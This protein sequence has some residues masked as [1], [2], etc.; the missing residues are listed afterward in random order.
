MLLQSAS[1]YSLLAIFTRGSIFPTLR[2][3]QFRPYSAFNSNFHLTRS[4]KKRKD[5]NSK[6]RFFESLVILCPKRNENSI[7]TRKLP[8]NFAIRRPITEFLQPNRIRLSRQFAAFRNPNYSLFVSPVNNSNYR[9]NHSGGNVPPKLVSLRSCTDFLT[10]CL[11]SFF[12]STI[13]SVFDARTYNIFLCLRST[14][15]NNM[16]IN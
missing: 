7:W 13:P 15:Y 5:Q 10:R 8:L 14:L 4:K 6:T 11:H 16:I 12:V 9:I 2:I 1:R 3:A